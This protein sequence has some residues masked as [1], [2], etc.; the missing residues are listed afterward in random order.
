MAR[1]VSPADDCL[2]DLDLELDLPW[3]EH[4][5]ARAELH[6][7]DPLAET[8]ALPFLDAADDAPGEDADDLAEH[9]RRAVG[10]DPDFVELVLVRARVIR[11]QEAARPV[12]DARDPPFDRRPVDVDV[13]RRQEDGDLRPPARRRR[14]LLGG[15]GDHHPAIRRRHDEASALRHL[16]VRIAEEIRE[17]PSEK[18]EGRGPAIAPGGDE[19]GGRD[20]GG[21]N[22]RETCAID[23]HRREC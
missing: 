7:A 15:P 8:D 17:E 14:P 18:R 19:A 23:F 11:G 12:L 20:H 1:I 5:H 6:Q 21:G 4:V 2:A 9:D 22:E 3:E 13:E 16:P 10:I